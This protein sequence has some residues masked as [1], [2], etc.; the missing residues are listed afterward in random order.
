VVAY[1]N[2]ALVHDSEGTSAEPLAHAAALQAPR[3]ARVLLLGGAA[4]GLVREVRKHRP[5]RVVA[6]AVD[7]PA[8][9]ALVAR[10]PAAD[11]AALAASEVEGRFEDPRAFRRR[12]AERF[13]VVLVGAP[14]PSSGQTNRFYTVEFFRRCA[15][16]LAAR[17][18]LAL[19]LASAENFW[20]RGQLV[21]NAAVHAALQEAF[22]HVLVLPGGTDV[23]LA[24]ASPLERDPAVLG[25]RLRARG[26]EAREV[27]RSTCGTS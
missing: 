6:V 1:E 18:V 4:S 14:E 26:V 17:G 25:E 16:R 8:Y 19:R 13:D 11:R 5:A 7:A 2:D 21:R 23:L 15:G 20:T 22:A 12:T 27:T 9:R 3:G 24:S 10:L